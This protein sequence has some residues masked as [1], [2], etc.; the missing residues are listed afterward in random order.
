MS[1][2][3]KI[4]FRHGDSIGSPS[5]ESDGAY[6]EH[7]FIDTGILERL[8][9]VGD[10]RGIVLGRTG[11][12][13]SALLSRLTSLEA[14]CCTVNPH[15]IV[16]GHISDSS[17]LG[18]F[19]GAGLNLEPFYRFL[20][21][22]IVVV[23]FIK[24]RFNLEREDQTIPLWQELAL[25]LRGKRAVL[26]GLEYLRTK[27]SNLLAATEQILTE[28]VVTIETELKG[29]LSLDLHGLVGM[30]AEGSRRLTTEQ[31][32]EVQQRGQRVIDAEQYS[33]LNVPTQ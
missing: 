28:N 17:V 8:R 32:Y 15:H 12:G 19:V 2:R 10:E 6:L 1:A 23:E 14:H 25:R 9:D 29:N 7:C 20:W 18:F 31:K 4:A 13:K 30:G 5:A 27:T 11:S 22:H 16:V 24:M 3:T 26:D 21:H 33:R